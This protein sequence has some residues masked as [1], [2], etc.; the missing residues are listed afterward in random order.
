MAIITFWN[1]GKEQSGKTLSIAAICT[2]Y[3]CNDGRRN[4]R[5]S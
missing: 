5:F 3:Q 1:N 2:K 4:S